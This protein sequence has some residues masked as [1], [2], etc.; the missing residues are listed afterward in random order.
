MGTPDASS[1]SWGNRPSAPAIY[2]MAPNLP[3]I[4]LQLPKR[5]TDVLDFV[6]Q[7]DDHVKGVCSVARKS[8]ELLI[9]ACDC[10]G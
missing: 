1:P 6:G 10:V 7:W 3:R 5:W 9:A 8:S 4:A 2:L